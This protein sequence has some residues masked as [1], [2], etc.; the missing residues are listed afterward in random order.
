M[1]ISSLTELVD[2]ARDDTPESRNMLIS[3]INNICLASGREMSARE[4]D[5]IYDIVAQLLQAVELQV[6]ENLAASLAEQ[7]D[8]PKE[9]VLAL[10]N[11]VIDV[12]RPVILKSKILE[13]QDLIQ[14]ILEKA[15]QHQLA[16]SSRPDISEDVSETLV[17]T[18]NVEVITSLL[19]NDSANIYTE[20][21]DK[22]V[23]DSQDV[24]NYQEALIKRKEL[25]QDMAKRMYGFVGDALKEH[26]ELRFSEE[27]MSIELEDAVAKAVN[28]AMEETSFNDGLDE[29]LDRFSP[30]YTANARGMVVALRDGD[31][32]KFEE[33]FADFSGLGHSFVTRILYD[34]GPNSLAI[35][36]RACGVSYQ[37][38]SDILCLLKNNANPHIF[39]SNP[40]YKKTM[41]YFEKMDGE[42][43]VK[44]LNS[45]RE[46]YPPIH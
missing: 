32:F 18:Q 26:L 42:G 6:R 29:I 15:E 2:I 3:S 46:S 36:C 23:D 28:D 30:N 9:L 39:A 43:A 20:T 11:D 35:C 33:L 25:H 19:H 12:A 16:V 21:I 44:V 4:K 41:D 24:E 1:N 38:F 7:Q 13:D 34:E 14:L 37:D 5:L 40:L 17:E 45:W 27:D 22:L 10:A 31:V 8:V